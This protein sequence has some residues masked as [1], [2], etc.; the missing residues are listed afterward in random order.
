MAIDAPIAKHWMLRYPTHPR[1][2]SH[3]TVAS[4]GN[5]RTALIMPARNRVIW[6]V[7]SLGDLIIQHKERRFLPGLKAGVSAPNI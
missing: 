4:A 3:R 7:A 2:R 1:S 5:R 6:Q